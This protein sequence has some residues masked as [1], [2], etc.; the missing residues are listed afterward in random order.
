MSILNEPG[1][2]L[3]GSIMAHVARMTLT[4]MVG[5]MF[6]FAVDAINLFWLAGTGDMELVAAAGFAMAVQV[7]SLACG[8]AMMIASTALI[9]RAIGA[10][11][12]G[13]ARR[14]TSSGAIIGAVVQGA[15]AALLIGFRYPILQ[16]L[17]AD[18]AVLEEAARYLTI[19]LPTLVLIGGSMVINGAIRAQGDAR[20]SVTVTLAGGLVS[21][22]F[23]Y[24]LIRVAGWGL[25]GA[26]VGVIIAQTASFL[27]AFRF[28]RKFHDLLARP[29]LADMKETFGP[30]MAIAV[31]AT[32]SQ[33]A[34]PAGIALL[35]MVM[36]RFGD[37]AVAGWSV[38]SRVIMV[39]YGGLLALS[40]AIG[41]IYGQNFGARDFERVRRTFRDATIFGLAYVVLVWALLYGATDW[42]VATFGVTGLGVEVVRAFTHFGAGGYVFAAGT[43]VAGAALNTLGRPRWASIINWVREGLLTWPF[44]V[45]MAGWFGAAGVVYSQIGVSVIIGIA[46]WL[47]ARWY[48]RSLD[49]TKAAEVPQPVPTVAQ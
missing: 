6:I 26:A 15:L 27:L 4:G 46:S 19:S 36:A 28:A 35:L 39:A 18:G 38:L 29:R 32:I 14:Q 33:L 5:F 17:G 49:E 8:I 21:L 30:F 31:P 42:V 45:V 3:T 1:R 2:F 11:D 25:V 9:S 34:R 23:G 7:M 41:G 16:F 40:A 48:I 24:L 10:G 13:L 44:S 20:R 47:I 12:P 37:E 22:I 43:F